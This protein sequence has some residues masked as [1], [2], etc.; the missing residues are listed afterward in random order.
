[1]NKMNSKDGIQIPSAAHQ[2][3]VKR[4]LTA[5]EQTQT[6]P[7]FQRTLYYWAA[8]IAAALVTGFFALNHLAPANRQNIEITNDLAWDA[9]QAGVVDLSLEDASQLLDNES[10]DAFINDLNI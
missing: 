5:Q 4:M 2:D 9:Y 7:L 3:L 10:I 8:S 6:N 1:M